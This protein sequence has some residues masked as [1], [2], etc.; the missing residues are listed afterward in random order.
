M[1][2]TQSWFHKCQSFQ[3]VCRLYQERQFKR[4]I[5]KFVICPSVHMAGLES[6]MSHRL[7]LTILPSILPLHGMVVFPLLSFL[8]Y[9][10][11]FI[12]SPQFV[13]QACN[14]QKYIQH[15]E[16]PLLLN[17]PHF[18]SHKQTKNSACAL[19]SSLCGNTNP[20]V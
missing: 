17:F 14:E 3:R 13:L 8:N 11:I 20:K 10:F 12:F 6:Q 2:G 18:K 4:V 9:Y 15:L 16:G 5:D 1:E 19:H 7:S